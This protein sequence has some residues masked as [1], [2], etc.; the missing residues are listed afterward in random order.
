L[1]DLLVQLITALPSR[2]AGLRKTPESVHG[3]DIWPVAI[4]RRA[5]RTMRIAQVTTPVV[6][7][8]RLPSYHFL[9][10]AIRSDW[11]LRDRAQ[12]DR[13]PT[14]AVVSF[15]C[16]VYVVAVP[17]VGPVDPSTASASGKPL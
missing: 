3:D 1:F 8:A 16:Q 12:R 14:R 5:F 17:S 9:G 2:L 15:R 13:T 6:R 7:F 10:A 11:K 4:S